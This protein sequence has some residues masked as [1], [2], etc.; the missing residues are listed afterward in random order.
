MTCPATVAGDIP[1][2]ID[3]QQSHSVAGDASHYSL[4]VQVPAAA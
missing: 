1:A 4:V 3:G 2:G